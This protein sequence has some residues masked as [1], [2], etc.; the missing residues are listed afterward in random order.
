VVAFVLLGGRVDSGHVLAVARD[1][2]LYTQGDPEERENIA[3]VVVDWMEWDTVGIV[4][5]Y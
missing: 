4:G 3:Q 5:S 1:G 2:C